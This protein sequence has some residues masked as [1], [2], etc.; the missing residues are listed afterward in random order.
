MVNFSC[1]SWCQKNLQEWNK[2]KLKRTST[3]SGQKKEKIST[4]EYEEMTEEQRKICDNLIE[5]KL[6]EED[7][8]SNPPL[9]RI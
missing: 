1:V 5:K 8:Q 7:I 2:L 9:R 6:I 4:K 3:P